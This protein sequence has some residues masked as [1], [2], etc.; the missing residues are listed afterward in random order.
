MKRI[1][2]ALDRITSRRT[3]GSGALSPTDTFA[4]TDWQNWSSTQYNDQHQTISSRLYFNIPASGSGGSG[5]HYAQ[6]DLGCDTLERQN[7]VAV[8]C[9]LSA[10]TQTIT[11]TV[12]ATPQRVDS[13][14]V[15]TNDTGATDSDPTGGGAAGNNMVIVTAN[16][17]DGGSAGGDGNLTAVT[18]YASATDTRVTGFDFDFRDR[19]T[20]QTDPD[21]VSGAATGTHTTWTLDNLDNQVRFQRQA[22]PTGNLIGQTDSSYDARGRAYQ[23]DIYAVDPATGAVGNALVGNTWFD[24]AGKVVQQIAPGAGQVFTKT[25]YNGVHWVTATYTGYNTT[26]TNYTQA[27]TPAN[28]IIIE[29]TQSTYDE[30]GHATSN[31]SSQRLND[32]N[33]STTGP[34]TSGNSR[35]MFTATWFDGI[36]RPIAT[37]NYGAAPSFT[38]PSTPPTASSSSVL[39]TASSYDEGGRAYQAIDPKGIV[40][41]KAFDNANRVTQTIEDVGGLNR[42]INYTWTLDGQKATMTAVNPTTGDQTTSWLYGTTLA[43]SRVARNDLLSRTVY[44]DALGW[45]TLAAGQRANLGVDDWAALPL[46]PGSDV[47]SQTYNRLGEKQTFTDQRG[48]VRTFYRD[49]L[50]RQTND[51]VTT[52]PAGVDS[53]V[54]QIAT[55]YE[56][57]GMVS[58][59][60]SYPNASTTSPGTPVNDCQLSYNTFAQLIQEYQSHAGAVVPG[61]TPSVQYAYDTGASGSN[62]IR[63]NALIYPNSRVVSYNSASGMDALLNRI[64]SISDPSA[65][66]AA[67]TYLGLATVV[68]ITYPQPSVWLDLWGG[69]SGVFAGLDLFNRVIDQRWQNSIT[70]TPTDIDRYKY[71]YDFNS[72]RIWKQNVVGT[73]VVS[74]G[75]DEYYTMDNLNRLTDMQRGVLNSMFTGITGTPALEQQWTL[76]RTGNWSQ[77]ATLAGGNATMT[78]DRFANAVNEITSITSVAPPPPP[79]GTPTPTA[80]VTPAYD[81]AGNMLTMPQPEVP[82]SAYTATYDAWHRMMSVSATSSYVGQYQYDGR[83]RRVVAVTTQTRHFYFTENWQDIEQRVGTATAM[84]QQ[85]VWGIR[86]VD[87]LVCRDNA[88]PE[89]LFAVQDARFNV[90][91]LCGLSGAVAERF[92]YDAYGTFTTLSGS[93]SA[94]SEGLN[95]AYFQQGW[96]LDVASWLYVSRRRLYGPTLGVWLQ[97]DPTDYLDSGNLYQY[98]RSNP[99]SRR[100]PSGTVTES[101]DTPPAMPC[102]CSGKKI[103]WEANWNVNVGGVLLT[104]SSGKFSAE[105][106]DDTGC[107]FKESGSGW[108]YFDDQSQP[109][110]GWYKDSFS[111]NREAE[112]WPVSKSHTIDSRVFELVATSDVGLSASE[113]KLGPFHDLAAFNQGGLHVTILGESV[114]VPIDHIHYEIYR[115]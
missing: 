20:G 7:R 22:T 56:I 41:Q 106:K 84:D 59:V 36:G 14:W 63:L 77:F 65:T 53:T 83:A 85:H 115:R 97:R 37:G 91:S 114:S 79:M 58:G 39:T 78:Q 50:G 96:Y 16:Q 99:A 76:D 93:W 34:L 10:A 113:G 71:G 90:T 15:G 11:R 86:Y 94:T 62:E 28:D 82:T 6:T 44:P 38:R 57:R 67:Y 27:Q 48:V 52:C 70:T 89:R 33:T 23:T 72:N 1:R 45:S 8:A 5:V 42:T 102:E 68:R 4:Q 55:A 3:T 18:R 109:L 12:W 21:P 98:L 74:G 81:A 61:T 30:G 95:W 26:G 73:P 111:D 51:C 60:T 49:K 107:L 112:L 19:R 80:W 25:A 104:I 101:D 110:I 47:T 75:L 17:Y 88:T 69:T 35:I 9:G 32:A 87:E 54:L 29:Q 2:R 40:A 43:T 24:P 108:A 100:D 31:A 103:K 92:V 64:T 66:L 46:D 13:V 105:G